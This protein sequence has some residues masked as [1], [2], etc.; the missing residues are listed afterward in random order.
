MSDIP[1]VSYI[2]LLIDQDNNESE[3]PLLDI[4]NS[5]IEYPQF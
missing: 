3:N 4:N 1:D 2:L 5:D